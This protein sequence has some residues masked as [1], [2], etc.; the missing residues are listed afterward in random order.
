MPDEES[1]ME[2]AEE[3]KEVERTG[4][5]ATY[6]RICNCPCPSWRGHVHHPTQTTFESKMGSFIMIPR[7]Q[8][9]AGTG[10]GKGHGAADAIGA[11]PTSFG[12]Q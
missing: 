8:A 6:V 3:W 12:S 4:S 11:L 2:L 9:Q 7:F 1:T 10:P 5:G